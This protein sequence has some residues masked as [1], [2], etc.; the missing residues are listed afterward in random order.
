[1][2][3][4]GSE[5]KEEY[6][7]KLKAFLVEIPPL[8]GPE[9]VSGTPDLKAP[10]TSAQIDA[11]KGTIQTEPRFKKYTGYDHESLLRKWL[12]DR[13]TTCNEFCGKCA[14]AM[15]HNNPNETVGRFDIAERLF[16]LGLGHVWVPANSSTTPEYGDVFRLY[17]A[18]PD[19]NGVSLNHMGVSLDV[20]GTDWYTVESGQGGPSK[21]HDAIK[22]KKR[23]WKESSL[24]GWVSMKALLNA[25]KPLPYW[26]GG[27][28]E[29]EEDPYGTYYYY[30]AAG[31][32]VTYMRERPLVIYSPLATG[33]VVIGS[34]VVK[35]L[36]D[37]E[38]T[39]RD[40][41]GP[42][43]LR[44]ITQE[45]KKRN[46]VMV[47]QTAKGVKLKATRLMPKVP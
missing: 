30:F 29:V 14:N 20:A 37:V 42:E 45:Q 4:E 6:Q 28:W 15:G 19:D 40:G 27:W 21:G 35:G 12:A 18:T 8:G 7:K 11:L 25:D 31:G 33:P 2:A 43:S 23:P 1:M 41:D 17:S 46:Y 36:F 22:R 39:W 13:T 32:K 9:I 47:G 10:F 26:L 38:I 16:S 44:I 24:Q 34:F 5:P 3:G